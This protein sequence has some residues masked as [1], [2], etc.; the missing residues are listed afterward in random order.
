MAYKI[1]LNNREKAALK[2]LAQKKGMNQK[3]VLRTAF[4]LYQTLEVRLERGDITWNQVQALL[5]SPTLRK[6]K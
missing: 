5:E 4:R 1:G 3:T 6:K 2:E